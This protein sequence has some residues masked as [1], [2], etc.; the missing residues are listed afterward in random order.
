MARPLPPQKS[1]VDLGSGAVRRV[2]R[3]RRDPPPPSGKPPSASEVRQREAWTITVGIAVMALVMFILV[4][5]L[6][7]IS[8]WSPGT[9]VV[10]LD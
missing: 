5:Q 7:T 3:I 8:S 4:L 1:K 2:S 10:N 9:I 6:G